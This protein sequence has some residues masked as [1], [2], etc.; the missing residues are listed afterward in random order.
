LAIYVRQPD[1]SLVRYHVPSL[2]SMFGWASAA[3]ATDGLKNAELLMAKH[4]SG[5]EYDEEWERQHGR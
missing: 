3:W 5:P 4:L 2:G 1:G